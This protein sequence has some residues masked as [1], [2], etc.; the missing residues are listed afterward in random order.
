MGNAVVRGYEGRVETPY[1][2]ARRMVAELFHGKP[3]GRGSRV[4]DAGS[5]RGVFIR[6]V[7]EYCRSRG[8]GLPEVVGV[9]VDPGLAGLASRVF[10]GYGSVRIVNADFLLLDAET[11]GRFDYVIGNP[12][13]VSYEKIDAGMRRIY[14]RMFRSAR[15]RFDLYMLFF[16]KALELLKPGG[17]L[18]FITP[19]KYLYTL[20][21]RELRRLLARQCVCKIEFIDEDAFGNILAYPVITVIEKTKT[22]RKTRIILRDG[23]RFTLNLPA[24][25][26][27]W[28]E[29]IALHKL[30][31]REIMKYRHRLEEIAVRISPG[32]ATGRDKVFI[33][34]RG[35]LPSNLERYAYPSVS[36]RELAM[37]K[38][39]NPIDPEKLPNT[40]L[41]PY[42]EHGKLLD[43]AQAKPLLD[44]LANQRKTL[45]ERRAV[46]EK[47]KKWYAFH[48]DPPMN[49]LLRPKIL[50]PDL[51]KEPIFYADLTGTIIPRHNTYY[52]VPKNPEAIPK[53]LEYLKRSDVKE[54][55]QSHSQ[56]AANGYIR[57][58]THTI[59]KLPIPD[60]L[61]EEST[62]G[63]KLYRYVEGRSP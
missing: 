63:R 6:A 11:L 30:E 35:K 39:F 44:Y 42:D 9:E 31:N 32:I 41:I 43:E 21:A 14:R 5:G 52:L 12:P 4:L 17:R 48:E 62:A 37:F 34:P 40:I 29:T 13:Y 2:L 50:W 46:Q 19:E 36:G 54:W 53:L 16:E 18:V 3:P 45:M 22:R 10:S 33:I 26:S 47:G 60:N 59:R 49:T 25:G 23:S 20:S 58:Q 61:Y 51:A 56:K 24:G 15:G 7:I 27:S 38:P 57:M 8:Y 1:W 55:I 28:L